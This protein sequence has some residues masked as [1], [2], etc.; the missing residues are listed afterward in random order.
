[1][2]YVKVEWNPKLPGFH[3][4]PTEY[5][6]ELPGLEGILPSGAWAFASDSEHYS[7]RSRRCVK[8]LELAD[9]VVPVGKE[10]KLTVHFSPNEWKHDDGLCIEYSGVTH[11][12][13]DRD[14]SIDWMQADTVMLDEIV[15]H[16]DGCL[17]EIALA[18]ST[19][20]VRCADLRATW[21][22]SVALPAP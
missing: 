2:K 20:T 4:D 22:S 17:H 15:P 9:I 8:D 16:P 7:F 11:F 5:L 10:G 18:D 14:Q 1:M 13:I 12:S 6:K 21:G 19:I 3:V